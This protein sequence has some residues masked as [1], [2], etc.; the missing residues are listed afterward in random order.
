MGP[1]AEQLAPRGAHQDARRATE[2]GNGMEYAFDF[3]LSDVEPIQVDALRDIIMA[4]VEACGGT[5]GGGLGI[6]VDDDDDEEP[7]SAAPR[8]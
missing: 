5:L 2:R 6:P 1:L 8:S 7:A 3:V 4:F